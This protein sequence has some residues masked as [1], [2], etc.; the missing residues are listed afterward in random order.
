MRMIISSWER[1][2]FLHVGNTIQ[3]LGFLLK[4][5]LV[6]TGQALEISTIHHHES[7]LSCSFTALPSMIDFNLM[8]IMF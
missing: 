5:N 2:R 1:N 7:L 4:L 6:K 3:L 8:C